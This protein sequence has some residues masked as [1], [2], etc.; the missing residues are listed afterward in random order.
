MIPCPSCHSISTI[1]I[2]YG[3][4][5]PELERAASRGLVELGSCI[6]DSQNPSR[7]CLDCNLAWRD[8]RNVDAVSFI[9]DAVVIVQKH[10]ESLSRHIANYGS[11]CVSYGRSLQGGDDHLSHSYPSMLHAFQEIDLEWERFFVQAQEFCNH[12]AGSDTTRIY[13]HFGSVY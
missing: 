9:S 5:G 6:V 11:A 2:A 7:R 4:P 8:S 13:G 12:Y 10:K 1:P 3:K